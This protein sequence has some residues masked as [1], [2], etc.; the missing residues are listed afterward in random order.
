MFEQAIDGLRFAL[1][2]QRLQGNLPLSR[3]P[4]VAAEL[5]DP[6]GSVSYEL[7]GFVDGR[8]RPGIEVQ[9]RARF[10]LVCQRC[11]NGLDFDLDRHTRFM[12]VA[13]EA[14]LPELGEEETETEAVPIEAVAS[15]DDLIE[16]EILLGLPIAPSHPDGV[17]TAPDRPQGAEP[18][19]PF[20][21]LRRLKGSE[22]VS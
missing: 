15:L 8:G 3:L 5:L 16:Q 13:D 12:L 19:S 10:A 14:A 20:A 7:K 18:D 21:V 2:G 22:N 1:E 17:C 11:L 6:A 4:R 9:T